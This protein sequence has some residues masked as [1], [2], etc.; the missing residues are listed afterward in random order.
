MYVK[1]REKI[2]EEEGEE[3]LAAGEYL[4]KAGLKGEK[5]REKRE[6]D[7][8]GEGEFVCSGTSEEAWPQSR[9]KRKEEKK[10]QARKARKTRTSPNTLGLKKFGLCKLWVKKKFSEN[11][12][13]KNT[14]SENTLL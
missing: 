12:L 2:C 6:E 14:L 3:N 4:R 9:K 5:K 11:T 13:S 8:R 1:K 7:A 10:K